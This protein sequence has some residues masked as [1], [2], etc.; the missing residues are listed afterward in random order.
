[1]VA[2]DVEGLLSA[3]NSSESANPSGMK[4]QLNTYN[5]ASCFLLRAETAVTDAKSAYQ[6]LLHA[7]E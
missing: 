1:M 5:V 3:S 6:L 2:V 7:H 4:G